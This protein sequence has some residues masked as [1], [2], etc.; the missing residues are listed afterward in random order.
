[1]VDGVGRDGQPAGSLED[2][3][4]YAKGRYPG[5][6]GGDD[7]FQPRAGQPGADH[8]DQAG[9]CLEGRRSVPGRQESWGNVRWRGV[10]CSF[11]LTSR[12][13]LKGWEQRGLFALL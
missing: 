3:Q 1:M 6:A 7:G 12:L 8:S 13:I 11:W 9:L 5:H 2:G 10:A 4:G